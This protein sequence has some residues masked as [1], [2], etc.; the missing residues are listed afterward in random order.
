VRDLQN[1]RKRA[2]R[3]VSAL[4]RAGR[5]T[6]HDGMQASS[7]RTAQRIAI[8]LVGAGVVSLVAYLGVHREARR[9]E[10]EQRRMEFAVSSSGLDADGAHVVRI[11]VEGMTCDGCARSVEQEL[12]KVAGVTACRV[13]RSS[14]VAEVRLASVDVPTD[15]LL[16]AVHDAGFEGQLEPDPPAAP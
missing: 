5:A 8:V 12:R 16:A 11:N 3:A 14:Q 2:S 7:P 13:D 4:V 6:Q 9:T 10:L 15:V 1:L